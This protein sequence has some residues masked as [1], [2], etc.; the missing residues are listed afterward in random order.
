[1][2]ASTR[3]QYS[4]ASAGGA[5]LAQAVKY[6]ILAQAEI[7]RCMNVMNSISAGG[8]TSANLEGSAEFGAAVG[9]GGALY[10][11]ANNLKANLAVITPAALGDLDAGIG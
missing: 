3:I 4:Q 1:M 5:H 6:V 10:T 7:A 9:Q 2:A 11:A 8:A